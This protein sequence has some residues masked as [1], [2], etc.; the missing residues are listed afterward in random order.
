MRGYTKEQMHSLIEFARKMQ[1]K[2]PKEIKWWS[3][4]FALLTAVRRA[5]IP[6]VEW[7]DVKKTYIDINKELVGAQ[8]PYT[9]KHNTKTNKDRYFPITSIMLDYLKRLHENNEIYHP[10]SKYLFPDKNEPLGCITMNV[11]YRAHKYACKELGIPIDKEF[12][13]GTHAFRRVHETTFLEKG[14][15]LDL[16]SKVYGNSPRVVED[17]YML[18]VNAES[19]LQYI[20]SIHDSLFGEHRPVADNDL[21]FGC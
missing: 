9:I 6:P 2:K 7:F 12:L 17:N 10:G 21:L 8:K 15:S 11:T 13:K 3:Y 4:E 1:K 5:E 19:S 18:A 14:G 20:Q 16:A